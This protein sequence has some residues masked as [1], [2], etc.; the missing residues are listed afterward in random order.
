MAFYYS[1][2]SR[3]KSGRR[4]AAGLLRLKDHLGREVP[5]RT[6]SDTLN[7]ATWNIRE[8]DSRKYGTRTEESL[9]HIAEIISC[10][11]LVA[12]QE[13]REDL[14]ALN[15][16]VSILGSAWKYLLTDVTEGTRGNRERMAFLYD[17]R[18]VQFGG[19]A[20]ELVLPPSL[21]RGTGFVPHLQFARSPF[22]AGFSAG[23]FRFMLCTVHVVYG[24]SQADDPQRVRELRQL[25]EFLRKR[26]KSES[27][28]S[29]NLILL[30][31]F[32]I[33]NTGD[34][35]FKALT[36]KGFIIPGQIQELPSN[37]DQSRHYDQIAFMTGRKMKLEDFR[38]GVFNFFKTV[39]R[40]NEEPT[41]I[42][43]MGESYSRKK[44][45]EKRTQKERRTY[46][47][48]WRTFQMSDHLP[49]WVQ[50]KIDFGREYL[51]AKTKQHA[52]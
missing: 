6:L 15:R 2:D 20:G 30:G 44:S 37:I 10:F 21:K 34:A 33:F 40:D 35:T 31:D 49:M 38:A 16:L 41:Y 25:A 19:L 23:W 1:I 26:A 52:R 13:I 48:A 12:V 28:W 17:E 5:Q 8:F 46:Y 39:Y 32:N 47:R 42:E 11:D 18:K 50:L 9:F 14:K 29:N 27:A 43:E 22:I 3:K 36:D 45:G 24:A 7:L 4:T 51:R